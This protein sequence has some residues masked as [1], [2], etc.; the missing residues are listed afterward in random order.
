M[1]ADRTN[2]I[3]SERRAPAVILSGR[4]APAVILSERSA[5]TVILS[6][7]SES[8]DLKHGR[9]AF[10]L[11]K[12]C[13]LCMGLLIFLCLTGCGKY[14]SS[15][16]AVGFVHSNTSDS[17]SMSFFSFEGRMV[18]KLKYSSE[19][20]TI[21]AA[22]KLESGSAVVYFDADGTKEEWFRTAAGEKSA[23]TLGKLPAGTVYIIVETD[24]ACQNGDFQFEIKQQ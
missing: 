7:R 3:L 6:E 21:K 8:K 13:L 1:D 12:L 20:Q 9:K 11:T 24:G 22:G 16:K 5:P 18:F 17:A 10:S 23:G 14:V 19:E 15:Y 2:V 4:S